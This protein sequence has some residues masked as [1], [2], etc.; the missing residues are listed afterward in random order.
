MAEETKETKVEVPL[1]SNLD[2]YLELYK[3][4]E[5]YKRVDGHGLDYGVS[6]SKIVDG[7]LQITDEEFVELIQDNYL[8]LGYTSMPKTEEILQALS[9]AVKLSGAKD[10]GTALKLLKDNPS[11]VK[12]SY[13]KF[14]EHDEEN[15][16]ASAKNLTESKDSL[17]ANKKENRKHKRRRF[18][19]SVGKV[20]T[21]LGTAAL[22]GGFLFGIFSLAGGWAGLASI[23]TMPFLTLSVV[24][25]Y[26][27]YH[28]VKAVVSRI[29]KG[30]TNV[31]N[32]ANEVIKGKEDV[33]GSNKSLKNARQLA[34]Q[35]SK[36]LNL[37]RSRQNAHSVQN[38]AAYNAL[39]GLLADES[40]PVITHQTISLGKAGVPV[41]ENKLEAKEEEEVIVNQDDN[42]VVLEE[43][44][45][46][47][48]EEVEETVLEKKNEGVEVKQ[49]EVKKEEEKAEE[50]VV[51]R[52]N[53]F[54]GLTLPKEDKEE[55]VNQVVEEITQEFDG[56]ISG[57]ALVEVKKKVK[58][59][60]EENSETYE[61]DPETIA[62]QIK[63]QVFK[64]KA[65][66]GKETYYI[67]TTPDEVKE[68]VKKVETQKTFKDKKS[69]AILGDNGEED[70][71]TITGLTKVSATLDVNAMATS[72][73]EKAKAKKESYVKAAEVRKAL[74]EEYSK[75]TKTTNEKTLTQAIENVLSLRLYGRE[76]ERDA[77]GMHK[78]GP[79]FDSLVKEVSEY[80][81]EYYSGKKKEYVKDQIKLN[82]PSGSGKYA[83]TAEKIIKIEE[84][85]AAYKAILNNKEFNFVE[86]A[87]FKD[88]K[89][90]QDKVAGKKYIVASL[91]KAIIEELE[92]EAIEKQED[93][94][95]AKGEAGKLASK[96]YNMFGSDKA[97]AEA[98]IRE[99]YAT[100]INGKGIDLVELTKNYKQILAKRSTLEKIE[101]DR[102]G[103]GE[104]AIENRMVVEKDP[105]T[106][107]AAIKDYVKNINITNPKKAAE[108]EEKI[109]NYFVSDLYKQQEVRTEDNLSPAFYMYGGFALSESDVARLDLI[110]ELPK[111]SSIT[112]KNPDGKSAKYTVADIKKGVN[113]ALVDVVLEEERNS[114]EN[115]AIKR[116]Q[117]IEEFEN[118]YYSLFKNADEKDYDN[119]VRTTLPKILDANGI[120]NEQD[121]AM[122]VRYLADA[123]TNE[124]DIFALPENVT[125]AQIVKFTI[126]YVEEERKAEQK[127]VQ[128]EQA[129]K[130][131][132]EQA[133]K[134]AL[135]KQNENRA[136]YQKGYSTLRRGEAYKKLSDESVIVSVFVEMS[137]TEGFN[138]I[139]KEYGIDVGNTDWN[140]IK[141][142]HP[143]VIKKLVDWFTAK[144]SKT[145]LFN[146][147]IKVGDKEMDLELLEKAILTVMNKQFEKQVGDKLVQAENT[148]EVLKEE[149][150]K[151]GILGF[152]GNMFTKK[153]QKDEDVEEL[154]KD[155]EEKLAV[156]EQLQEELE[157][158]EEVVEETKVVTETARPGVEDKGLSIKELQI[159]YPDVDL[160]ELTEIYNALNKV[161]AEPEL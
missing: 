124:T 156:E 49:E 67:T 107:R 26:I 3:L 68:L 27:A 22:A 6:P 14:K 37:I 47:K 102:E 43:K 66:N 92:L 148:G 17:K 90:L 31:I 132:E 64:S 77:N 30:L 84:I 40:I 120:N 62:K 12:S 58:K 152:I 33:L 95:V 104:I 143:E 161:E 61:S 83:F 38:Y 87:D 39:E 35:N 138:A 113:E 101:R 99:I 76:I 79:I 82:V 131:A 157:E 114:P 51:N 159:K 42:E 32:K 150:K 91:E 2:A 129:K 111:L 117:D 78:N 57:S 48:V 88:I 136:I 73:V 109:Y 72:Y 5:A 75:Q 125:V 110:D 139:L 16:E 154:I 8:R 36:A 1:F 34:K 105:L 130:A 112:V 59:H 122:I 158:V 134:E 9:N 144:M 19:A 121:Q 70:D 103:L 149:E 24:A 96:L 108:V 93:Y 115:M 60:F 74:V 141:K 41:V 116:G 140:E 155:F 21:V 10:F 133:K 65:K 142:N 23:S 53:T 100:K 160:K 54:F 85:D 18:W 145:E 86:L 119:F 151:G 11:L 63:V 44:G 135:Q 13:K 15:L 81:K 97:P 146:N 71:L 123:T 69:V 20:G 28:A 89:K 118:A 137:S 80:A 29:W 128:E 46:D 56:K 98:Q 147:S 4:V 55:L 25:G 52:E 153:V 126:T 127:R 45:K 50:V 106:L 7:E 94:L